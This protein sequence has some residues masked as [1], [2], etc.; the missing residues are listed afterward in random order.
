LQTFRYRKEGLGNATIKSRWRL[1]VI[2]TLTDFDVERD[3]TKERQFETFGRGFHVPC[4]EGI[5]YLSAGR[6]RISRHILY[7]TNH[8]HTRAFE[9]LSGTRC[10]DKR[11]ILRG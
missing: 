11:Q 6:A 10:V 4:T 5:G 2:T 8:R 3:P 9:Q 7:Q 1:A